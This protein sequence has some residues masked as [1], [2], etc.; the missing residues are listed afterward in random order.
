MLNQAAQLRSSA[1]PRNTSATPFIPSTH[2]QM[3]AYRKQLNAHGLTQSMSRK[4]NCL[5]NAAMESFFG[6]LKS[7]FFYLNK[8][9]DIEELKTGLR[10]YIRYYNHQRIKL[11][12]YIQPEPGALPNS[13]IELLASNRPTSGGQ[14]NSWWTPSS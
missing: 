3:P 11:K 1:S 4:G 12:L 7:E 14:F 9:A 5:D 2:Y 8:F 6:T 10:G 13:G